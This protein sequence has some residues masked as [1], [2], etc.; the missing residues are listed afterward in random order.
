VRA[1]TDLRFRFGTHRSLGQFYQDEIASP[2]GLDFYIRLPEDIPNSS[3]ATIQRF[4]PVTAFFSVGSLPI[5]FAS[6][7]KHSPLH[8]AMFENPGLW[9]PLDK[10]RIYARNLEVPSGG[11]VGTARAIAHA[12]SVFAT[13]GHELGLYR[14]TLETLMASAIPPL[15]GFYDECMM[16]EISFSLGFLKPCQSYPY[17]SSSAFG[18]PG[19]GGPSGL[20]T[21]RL[22]GGMRMSVIGWVQNQGEIRGSWLFGMHSTERLIRPLH[23]SRASA[24]SFF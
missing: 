19:A 18:S 10:E 22:R 3:L 12:Y 1:L 13:G 20:L 24:F 16:N 21:H 15:N 8:R 5:L 11:G 23:K 4:N 6:M 7:N 2:L 14:G 17:G 9:L